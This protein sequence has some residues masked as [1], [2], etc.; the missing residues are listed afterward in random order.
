MQLPV[1]PDETQNC[2]S[3][4]NG[5]GDEDAVV[6]DNMAVE[7]PGN[8]GK[9]GDDP[10]VP[11]FGTVKGD[12][13]Q[14]AAHSGEKAHRSHPCEKG[15]NAHEDDEEIEPEPVGSPLLFLTVIEDDFPEDGDGVDQRTGG[16]A[17]HKLLKGGEKIAEELGAEDTTACFGVVNEKAENGKTHA[18]NL[19]GSIHIHY[20]KPPDLWMLNRILSHPAGNSIE[21]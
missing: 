10:G 13:G 5:N 3:D 2:G 14:H 20:K 21:Q 15:S 4:L 9:N 8:Q 1:V 6:G 17:Y 16:S 7:E 18:E 11:G 12:D 19:S